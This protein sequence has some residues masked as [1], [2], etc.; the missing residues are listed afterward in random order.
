MSDDDDRDL[1]DGAEK[2]PSVSFEPSNGGHPMGEMVT[3]KVTGKPARRQDRDDKT[4]EPLTWPDGNPKWSIVVP[5]L[6]EIN[7]EWVQRG[8]WMKEIRASGSMYNALG[9]AR[10]EARVKHSDPNITIRKGCVIEVAWVAED[11]SP[12]KKDP[13]NSA[14]KLYQARLT[15]APAGGEDPWNDTTGENPF[16]QETAPPTQDA[17]PGSGDNPFAQ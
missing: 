9:V 16:N 8:L 11:P 3:L 4:G 7:G 10:T 12:K 15:P 1:F 13:K 5:V 17:I 2:I 14:I 6:E